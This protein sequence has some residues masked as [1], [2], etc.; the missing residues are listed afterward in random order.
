[1]SCD[2]CWSG[3]Y[4]ID[5]PISSVYI[6]DNSLV[7][8][9]SSSKL[10]KYCPVCGSKLSSDFKFKTKVLCI[11][12]G[13]FKTTDKAVLDKLNIARYDAKSSDT[14]YD[15][16]DEFSSN[17]CYKL[18]HTLVKDMM[19]ELVSHDEY[20]DLIVLP[21]YSSVRTVLSEFSISY[22]IVVPRSKVDYIVSSDN[23]FE[24]AIH[25][26]WDKTIKSFNDD[27]YA[28]ETYELPTNTLDELLIKKG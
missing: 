16:N 21:S 5:D 25:K 23:K 26:Y 3:K 18:S 2:Y 7:L 15:Y 12:P 11:M 20:Y 13:L 8:E 28:T 6:D 4:L 24:D 9:G 14:I 10:I 17:I 1:M 22:T 27:D 19:H